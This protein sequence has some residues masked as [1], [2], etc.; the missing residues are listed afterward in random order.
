[1]N[2]DAVKNFLYEVMGYRRLSELIQGKMPKG[3]SV[4]DFF[5][6]TV[7]ESFVPNK[8]FTPQTDYK[9]GN[10]VLMAHPPNIPI[11]RS[12]EAIAESSKIKNVFGED[13]VSVQAVPESEFYIEEI[14]LGQKLP[15]I[16]DTN[17]FLYRKRRS[18]IE[19][20]A[21]SIKHGFFPQSCVQ[22]FLSKNYFMVRLEDEGI[23][24]QIAGA[25]NTNH[26]KRIMALFSINSSE[27]GHINDLVSRYDENRFWDVQEEKSQTAKAGVHTN[28]LGNAYGL[29]EEELSKFVWKDYS[30]KNNYSKGDVINHQV[31]GFGYI[32]RATDSRIYVIFP[33]INGK[34]MLGHNIK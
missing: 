29:S 9:K 14:L 13:M 25:H 7:F 8:R 26:S 32:E 22:S 2:E 20:L 24:V 18:D 10:A 34:K 33:R 16:I 4:R 21:N 19:E 28:L 11:I 3:T 17:S 31:F 23:H 5:S 6:G 15:Y 27:V 1:M 30:F 12:I